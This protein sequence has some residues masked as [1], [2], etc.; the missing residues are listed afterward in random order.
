MLSSQ[1]LKGQ[2]GPPVPQ[3]RIPLTPLGIHTPSPTPKADTTFTC[4][5]V[6][7]FFTPS[8]QPCS[9]SEQRTLR[10][11]AF[12]S[13]LSGLLA[14]GCPAS[15]H[16]ASGHRH[17]CHPGLWLPLLSLPCFA[18]NLCLSP[19]PLAVARPVLFHGSGSP[20]NPDCR[21][22]DLLICNSLRALA[23]RTRCLP[24]NING[25]V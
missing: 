17:A 22:I 12:G 7:N 9:S 5:S 13:R 19:H 6:C 21:L 3:G 11:G 23:S 2:K 20:I 18:L 8:H 15:G 1:G 14:R 24:V 25:R 16:L 4:Q 10:L